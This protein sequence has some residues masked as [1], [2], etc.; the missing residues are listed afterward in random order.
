M[1]RRRGGSPRRETLSFRAETQIQCA[2]QCEIVVDR[3]NHPSLCTRAPSYVTSRAQKLERRKTPMIKALTP[4]LRR[5]SPKSSQWKP[6]PA[7]S[8]FRHL[9]HRPL[10]RA[11]L[12]SPPP[13][14][15]MPPRIIVVRDLVASFSAPF[16]LPPAPA[17]PT[18]NH[19]MHARFTSLRARLVQLPEYIPS[20]GDFALIIPGLRHRAIEAE[21]RQDDFKNGIIG[22][23]KAEAFLVAWER[24]LERVEEELGRDLTVP[25]SGAQETWRIIWHLG[26]ECYCFEEVTT[27]R[28]SFQWPPEA[29]PQPST[30]PA[31]NSSTEVSG[32]ID[33]N[34]S[35]PFPSFSSFNE[36]LLPV[37][38][39]SSAGESKG[40]KRKADELFVEPSN[41]KV[42]APVAIR[43]EVLSLPKKS[44]KLESL[45]NK[46]KAVSEELAEDSSEEDEE[47]RKEKQLYNW[48]RVQASE[49][50]E[51]PNFAPVAK[52]NV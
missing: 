23:D 52:K 33:S 31:P 22:V 28:T 19:P 3:G 50:T 41:S 42:A 20:D 15:E 34:L 30:I 26:T 46:W 48:A 9:L 37:E 21:L 1:K 10:R 43:P 39:A 49:D 17:L 18:Q 5:S 40:M 25:D 16:S 2:C 35:T 14:P 47:Y 36:N 29:I 12:R 6:L 8:Q 24:R 38:D 44:K 4:S 7:P 32:T 11:L 45:L 51:N 13:P 27:G